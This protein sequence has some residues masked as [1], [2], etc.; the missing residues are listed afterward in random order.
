MSEQKPAFERI[1][2]VSLPYDRRHSDDKKNYGI[3]GFRIW[4]VLK[5]PKGAVQ[6]MYGVGAYLPHL[7]PEY[8]AKG[9]NLEHGKI[10]GW[11]VGYHAY[12]PQYEDQKPM[13]ECDILGCEC[14]YDGSGLRADDWVNEIFSIVGEDPSKRLWEKLEEE[15]EL[16]FSDSV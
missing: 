12:K 9:L 13:G 5:G 7:T 6:F 8:Y 14:Y 3:G 15:Y 4:H 16:Q 11:D 2:K 1:T 10:S